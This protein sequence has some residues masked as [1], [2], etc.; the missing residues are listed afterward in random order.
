MDTTASV[1]VPVSLVDVSINTVCHTD[2]NGSSLLLL[3]LAG[4]C[5]SPLPPDSLPTILPSAVRLKLVRIMIRMPAQG[6][7]PASR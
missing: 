6:M 3:K 7:S 4:L 2:V 1:V 5:F